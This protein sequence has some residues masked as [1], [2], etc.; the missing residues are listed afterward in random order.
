[1]ASS[2]SIDLNEAY[3]T[4][5]PQVLV[6]PLPKDKCMGVKDPSLTLWISRMQRRGSEYPL[7]DH[8]RINS[9]EFEVLYRTRNLE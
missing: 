3:L 2:T 8:S 5:R 1:M 6:M 4:P 9:K 7:L